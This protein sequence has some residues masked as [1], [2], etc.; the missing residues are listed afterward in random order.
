MTR[1]TMD[2]SRTISRAER[3]Q[4]ERYEIMDELVNS[5]DELPLLGG[6]T[7]ISTMS[8]CTHVI[9]SAVAGY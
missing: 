1:S 3:A 8:R 6:L 7:S 4:Q 5:A 2:V 9:A